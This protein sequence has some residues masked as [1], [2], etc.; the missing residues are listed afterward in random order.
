MACPERPR[1]CPQ[2][3][4][5]VELASCCLAYQGGATHRGAGAETLPAASLREGARPTE[6]IPFP[7][8]TCHTFCSAHTALS[9]RAELAP[10]CQNAGLWWLLGGP[11]VI[12]PHHLS[13]IKRLQRFQGLSASAHIATE[14]KTG[15]RRH[16][17]T[18][19]VKTFPKDL[20]DRT[21]PPPKA[22]CSCGFPFQVLGLESLQNPGNPCLGVWPS[23]RSL[24]KS[25]HLHPQGL[26]L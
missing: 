4:V 18:W 16:P 23:W 17:A 12:R 5:K 2:H 9:D 8:P 7:H 6:A 21:Q 22:S 13:E 14:S 11:G 3:C 19:S 20:K 24:A 10:I 15:W 1:L 25:G 26:F